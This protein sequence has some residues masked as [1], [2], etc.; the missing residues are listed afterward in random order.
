MEETVSGCCRQR[1]EQFG[2]PHVFA[3]V[4]LALNVPDVPMCNTAK[5]DPTGVY[6]HTSAWAALMS[7]CASI[8]MSYWHGGY[9]DALNLYG[10]FS[11]IANFVKGENLAAG[12]YQPVRIDRVEYV[13]RPP[14]RTEDLV[15]VPGPSIKPEKEFVV[16][17]DGRLTPPLGSLQGRLHGN[18]HRDQKHPPTFVVDYKT[19]GR[20][21]ITIGQVAAQGRLVVDLDGQRVLDKELPCG[22]KIG[23]RS[24]WVEPYKIW[25]STY[26]ETFW[27]DVPA[28]KHRVFVDN[29]GRDS[30]D[31]TQYCLTNYKTNE[32]PPLRV[33]AMVSPGR[34]LLWAQNDKFQWQNRPDLG[35]PEPVPPARVWLAGL[36]PGGGTIEFWD[37][38]KG[39][40]TRTQDAKAN[41]DGT[42]VL[43]LPVIATD[44]ALKITAEHRSRP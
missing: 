7:G 31:V 42:L 18:A 13:T 25:V 11:G 9:I 41:E 33:W 39:V 19:P 38:Q 26:D 17:R 40:C 3:E 35:L 28:G 24:R 1:W 4:G 14:L 34:T 32:R 16:H 12:G 20:L 29:A 22:E 2:K 43:E 30:I 23:K 15:V 36:K 44:V 6:L 21:G 37:T 8:P 10:R 5:K 27:I